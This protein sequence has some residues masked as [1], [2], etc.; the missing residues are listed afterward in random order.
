MTQRSGADRALAAR[1]DEAAS[2][3][4]SSEAS[5]SM[6]SFELQSFQYWFWRGFRDAANGAP[7]KEDWTE[8]PENKPAASFNRDSYEAGRA[9]AAKSEEKAPKGRLFF[10]ANKPDAL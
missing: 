4:L 2:A 5:P 8:P 6:S 3:L 1:A 7:T 9:A 10:G